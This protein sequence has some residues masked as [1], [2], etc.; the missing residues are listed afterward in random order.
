MLLLRQVTARSN[1]GILLAL[2][3][4]PLTLLLILLALQLVAI[5]ECVP[6]LRVVCHDVSLHTELGIT[7]RR[8]HSKI[9]SC[10]WRQKRHHCN[11]LVLNQTRRHDYRSIVHVRGMREHRA[12]ERDADEHAAED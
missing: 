6:L 5:K 10:G 4:L 2:L 3:Q 7:E 1:G 11:L 12:H 8:M 9:T